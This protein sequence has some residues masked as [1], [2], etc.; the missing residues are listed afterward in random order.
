MGAK[1]PIEEWAG[2]LEGAVARTSAFTRVLVMGEVESTQ[3]AARAAAV[4][5]VIIAYRQTRGR[6]RL[7]RD[8]LDTFDDGLAMS[9]VLPHQIGERIAIVAAIAAGAA[10]ERACMDSEGRSP[11]VGIKWPNDLHVAR[12]KVGG[13]LIERTAREVILGIGINCSQRQFPGELAQRAISLAM[14]GHEVD[15]V[16]LAALVVEEVDRWMRSGDASLCEEFS[17]RDALRGEAARFRTPAGVVCGTVQEI[18]PLSGITLL[19]PSGTQFLPAATT[20]L[21]P[22]EPSGAQSRGQAGAE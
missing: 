8:W 16:D 5:S 13:I 19:T 3:D 14:A 15:R 11:Q 12:R 9:C 6:G 21:I 10:I 7:G 1:R 2:V 17:R 22:P 20:T 4:G 18:E